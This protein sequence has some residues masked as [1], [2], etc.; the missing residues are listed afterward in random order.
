MQI[1]QIPLGV[2]F[3]NAVSKI[4]AQS[5]NVSFA[6]FQWKE[7]FKLWALSFERAFE[8][9]T[10]SGIGCTDVYMIH[11]YMY[12]YSFV[13]IYTVRRLFFSTFDT[14]FPEKPCQMCWRQMSHSASMFLRRHTCDNISKYLHILINTSTYIYICIYIYIFI[15]IHV[16][17]A[18]FVWASFARHAHL[19]RKFSKVSAIVIWHSKSSGMMCFENL[20]LARHSRVATCMRCAMVMTYR[21][22]QA[23]LTCWYVYIYICIY[24]RI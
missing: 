20:P 19:C 9:V 6:T 18:T 13:Y 4:K 16:Y 5:S 15:Y 17:S 12:I 24:K 1:Q 3:S 8:N 10:P 11:M 7:T 23:R 2:T 22:V 21:R 14:A